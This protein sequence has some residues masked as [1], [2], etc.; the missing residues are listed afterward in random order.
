VIYGLIAAIG[1]GASAIAATNAARRAGTYIAV[2]SGQGV[3]VVALVLLAAFLH[4]SLGAVDR[5]AAIGLA[6]AGLLGLLGY[7]TYYRALEYGGAVG[8]ISAISY[9]SGSS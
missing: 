6:G 5:P 2:L 4:P 9:G 3:G 7:L 8:L 1:W